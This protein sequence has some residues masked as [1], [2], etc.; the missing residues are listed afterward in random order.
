MVQ[1]GVVAAWG[2]LVTGHWGLATTLLMTN[3]VS[4]FD[5]FGRVAGAV[6]T[7][8]PGVRAWMRATSAL[9]GGGDITTLPPGVDL[10]TGAAPD[11]V[12]AVR[13]PLRSLVVRRSHG[14]PRRRHRGRQRRRPDRLGG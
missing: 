2:G 10:R 5:W 11:P 3:A 12:P 9:S 4:G 7:E 14:R 8:A 13:D 6:V 1:C